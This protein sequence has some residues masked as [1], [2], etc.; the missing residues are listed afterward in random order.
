MSSPKPW[1]RSRLR[2]IVPMMVLLALCGVLVAAEQVIAQEPTPT[3]PPVVTYRPTA[4]ETLPP[5]QG[6][7]SAAPPIP[8]LPNWPGASWYVGPTDVYLPGCPDWSLVDPNVGS[9]DNL[10]YQWLAACGH[11]LPFGAG[12]DPSERITGT[13]FNATAS[14]TPLAATAY[15]LSNYSGWNYP[16][17]HYDTPPDPGMAYEYWQTGY[18]TYLAESYFISG[19]VFTLQHEGLGSAGPGQCKLKTDPNY[20]GS[21]FDRVEWL[22]QA[23][24]TYCFGPAAACAALAPGAQWVNDYRIINPGSRALIGF[25]IG[26][27]PAEC[28]ADEWSIHDANWILYRMDQA[29]TATPA[30]TG[31]PAPGYKAGC[32]STRR[33]PFTAGTGQITSYPVGGPQ[34][35]YPKD[36]RA[37]VFNVVS[38]GATLKW[39]EAEADSFWPGS[40]VG[41][42]LTDGYFCIGTPEACAAAGPNYAYTSIAADPWDVTTAKNQ[43][44]SIDAAE[45]GDVYLTTYYN[46]YYTDQAF[47]CAPPVEENTPTPVPSSTPWLTPTAGPTSAPQL[48]FHYP[49]WS[50]IASTSYIDCTGDGNLAGPPDGSLL[51]CTVQD[52]KPNAAVIIAHFDPPVQFLGYG[53]N[54]DAFAWWQQSNQPAEWSDYLLHEQGGSSCQQWVGPYQN[55]WPVVHNSDACNEKMI[56]Y[57]YIDIGGGSPATFSWDTVRL[58][59]YQGPPATAT[60]TTTPTSTPT[61]TATPEHLPTRTPVFTPT[62]TPQG[63]ADFCQFPAFRSQT[64]II[65]G[66]LSPESWDNLIQLEDPVCFTLIPGFSAHLP[67]AAGGGEVHF[68][69]FDLCFQY[70]RFPTVSMFGIPIALD[71]FLVPVFAFVLRQLMAL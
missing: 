6:A 69:E 60:P 58:Y 35:T 33:I 67:S 31:T 55:G 25:Q 20:A 1:I 48:G 56:D 23:G 53:P 44:F 40:L 26:D 41:T 2:W 64:P 9:T 71:W 34:S 11:C 61:R 39:A 51:T 10:A 18:Q 15:E 66:D 43:A 17:P 38:H 52:H 57:V 46:I 14:P 5:T 29:Y 65:G 54:G 7:T 36:L 13:P 49:A 63:G 32:P 70:V 21:A 19:I 50:E 28:G 27:Y 30:V 62:P 47:H 12:G 16:I 4:T 42:A 59:G 68:D 24:T 8:N 22:D 37:V 45:T 3:D